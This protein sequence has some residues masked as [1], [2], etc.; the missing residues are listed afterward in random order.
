MRFVGRSFEKLY[1]LDVKECEENIAYVKFNPEMEGQEKRKEKHLEAN[2]LKP[3]VWENVLNQTEKAV[4]KSEIGTL[5]F[6]SAINLL[7]FSPTYGDKALNKLIEIIEN[8]KDR[9]FLF[10]VS[11]SAFRDKIKNLEKAS[12]NLIFTKMEKPMELK[13]EITRMKE[14]RFLEKPRKVPIPKRSSRRYQRNSRRN[15]KQND[16]KN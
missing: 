5:F 6:S 16:S 12:E 13:I 7:L 15:K 8:R 3:E 11:I 4:E 9:S 2:L 1:G 14:V 10:A